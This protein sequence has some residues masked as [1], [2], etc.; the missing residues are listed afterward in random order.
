MSLGA[1]TSHTAYRVLLSQFLEEFVARARLSFFRN[2]E[3]RS[4]A[5]PPAPT[6]LFRRH[7]SM[8]ALHTRYDLSGVTTEDKL[9][10][11]ENE[12]NPDFYVDSIVDF[13]K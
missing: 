9:L 12:I 3:F 6:R 1:P 13:F 11:K 7:F 5:R 2:I 10:S 4:P 8:R